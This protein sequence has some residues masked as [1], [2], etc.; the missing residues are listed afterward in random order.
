M[1]LCRTEHMFFEGSRLVGMRQ[2]ILS[3]DEKSGREALA[4]IEPMQR[5]D[6]IDLFEIMAG[7][8]VTIRLLDPPLH[9]VLPRTPA[10]MEQVAAD[11][12]VAVT[13][14]EARAH[15][16]HEFN[17]MLGHRGVRL[18]VSYPEIYE[19]EARGV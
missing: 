6:F 12:C 1:G 17:P 9:E 7:L 8:P 14:G 15:K 18:G 3:D 11:L 19:R 2:M 13:G 16:L 10:E 5:Q 4:K